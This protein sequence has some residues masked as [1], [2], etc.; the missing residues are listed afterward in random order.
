MKIL[1]GWLKNVAFCVVVSMG[2]YGY[3][4]VHAKNHSDSSCLCI[5]YELPEL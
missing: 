1:Y 2:T 5:L 4:F 3:V